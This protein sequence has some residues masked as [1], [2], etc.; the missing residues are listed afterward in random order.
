M[1]FYIIVGIY[2]CLDFNGEDESD[3]YDVVGQDVD[4]SDNDNGLL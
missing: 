2:F 4:F 3:Y 1:F